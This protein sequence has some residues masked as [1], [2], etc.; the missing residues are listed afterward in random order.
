MNIEKFTE[1]ARGFLQAANTIAARESHQRLMPEHLLK[2]L[3]DDDQGMAANLIRKS[4][5]AP[6]RV[7][8]AVDLAVGK[9]PKVTGD[10]G[11]AYTD[12]SLVRV[13]D[14]AEKLATKAGD[15]F[16][17]VERVLMA[18]A[19]VK[20]AAKTA[21]DAG[22]VSAQALN[23]AINDLRQG[24]TADSA[25]AE[26]NYEALKK[27]AHDLT[28]A[29]REG[30]IDP[31]IGRDE[32]IRRTM[33]VLSRRGKN[34]PVLIGEPGVGKTAIAEG[35]ALRIINGDV[36][37]SLR[38]KTLMALDMGA[39]IAGAKYRGEFEERLKA[40]LNEIG[41]AAGEIILF[42][43]EMHTLV[44]AGK[45]EGA[46]DAAN[47]IKPALARGELHCVGAT[48]LD[49]YRKYVEK[50]AALA[51][52]FQPVLVQEP[53]VEDTISILRG[54]KEKYELHHGV[55]IADSAL[56]AASTL[57]HRYITDRFLPDK[58]I[59]LMDE[60]ASRLRME[61]DSKPEELDALDREILQKQIEAEALRK[62]DDAASRDRLGTLE[63]ELSELQQQSAEMTAQW[64]AERDLLEAARGLKEK[65]DRA[66]A[67]LDAAKRTGDF[68]KAGEIQ[69]STIP[70]LERELG[71]AEAREAQKL[72]GDAVRP[73]QIAEVVE[74]WTGIPT[75]R[76]L[77]GER[78]K[79]LRMEAELHKRVIGQHTAVTA[80]A[81]AVRRA[82]AGLNDEG[83]PLG[84]FLFLGPTGV[85]KTELTKAVAEFLFDDDSAMVRIDMSE[86]MEKHAVARLIGAPPGY[87]GYEEGGTLTEA[88]RRR[89][90][91]VVL[92][93]EVEKAH[94][95]VFNVLL[96]VLDDGVLT[97]SQGR[98]VDFKQ[99]LI[100]LTSNLGSQALS[101]VPD[102]A[103]PSE[104]R[105]HVMEAVRAHFRPEFLN[106]LDETVIFDRLSRADM[107][108]I[109]TI[110]M[111]R[112]LNRLATR[113]I[114]LDLDDAARTWLADK[115]YD[116]A[117]GAR[118]LKRVIQRYLQDPLAQMLLSGEVLDGA[119]VPVTTDASGLVIA[120]QS[121][122]LGSGGDE[123]RMKV[124]H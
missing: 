1:R 70:K 13:L 58:A 51:R 14:E 75:T 37:E 32:E 42:I 121:T 52:R 73:E 34:N 35:L 122:G 99:T 83:R 44:G 120:G 53:T 57:S 6:E 46:M 113:K 114:A 106:R 62:E 95:D 109:V 72:V 76:M 89:P 64:Q 65:L 102:G 117:Y 82:R 25:S 15:S 80:V 27:Y 39:L 56:V 23:T 50:D 31:I 108:G 40:V 92:F 105:G 118:P 5:G 30:K 16:V 93:D 100:I 101:T 36:P 78:E 33:Q 88:V 115:G 85:G 60:A 2:A 45:S 47:L 8:Q 103:D 86:Y 119:E 24:R 12:Q 112:L 107:D 22:A 29:A 81:N 4:G 77:E 74:R 18:L 41:A 10:A 69:Y 3:M 17:P 55:R 104:A 124:V 110:Q 38:D 94:P 111:Q 91:Q 28:E 97:D 67:D 90:Y 20:S 68:A 19:M 7:V 26:D 71:E 87:V 54:I 66:R 84:S 49:E 11:Q 9:L 59:D 48:T 96:Q 63:G 98:T 79:L 116:P 123:P 43:D 61:I 21:L